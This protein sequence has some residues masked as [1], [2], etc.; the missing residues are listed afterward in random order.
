MKKWWMSL[1]AL[2]VGVTFALTFVACGEEEDDGEEQCTAK[3]EGKECGS[4]G[5]D[6]TCGECGEGEKC[7]DKG[8]C[9]ADVECDKAKNCE[10]KECGDDLCGGTCGECAEGK[11]CS[12]AGKCSCTPVCVGADEVPYECGDDGCGGTCGTCP[13]G[14]YTCNAEHKCECT[15]ACEG[16]DCGPDGCGGTCGDCEEGSACD[17]GDN[18][19]K[20]VSTDC[21]P[22]NYPFSDVIQ[23]INW[24]SMGQGGHPGEALDVDGDPDTCAPADDC[25]GGLNNQLS[26]LL[27]QIKQFVDPD[28]EIAKALDEGQ[29][30]LLAENVDMKTDGTPFTINMYIGDLTAD[31][32]TCDYQA[33]KCDYVVKLDSLD[34]FECKPIISFDNATL[35]DG[36]L[37]AGGPAY[38]FQVAIP[39]S[40]GVVLVVTAEMAQIVGTITG[41]GDAMKIENGLIGGAVRKDKLMEAVDLIPEDAGL[42]VSKD[43]IKNIL[44][45]FVDPDVDTDDDGEP[46]GASVGV[47]FATIAGAIVGFEEPEPEPAQ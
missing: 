23:K 5:C 28:A 10:G 40:D 22:E 7:D 6:G 8:K 29:I 20:V 45:M 26:G 27:G 19:C 42:P 31:K 1:M 9:Q 43:M 30:V 15:P 44:N 38:D 39:I 33:A 46:D 3:C 34:K 41:E 35:N 2:A 16:K 37:A 11:T 14:P 12:A 24:M 18:T 4:D 32:E 36:A 21:P 47:K 17:M 25:E 13:V